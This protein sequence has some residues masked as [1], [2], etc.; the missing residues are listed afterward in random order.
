[1][2][3]PK[4]EWRVVDIFDDSQGQDVQVYEHVGNAPKSVQCGPNKWGSG[5]PQ[6]AKEVLSRAL[7]RVE[8]DEPYFI[9][10]SAEGPP[11]SSKSKRK[12]MIAWD[13]AHPNAVEPIA[14]HIYKCEV[15][16]KGYPLASYLAHANLDGSFCKKNDP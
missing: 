12:R 2:K 8:E 11:P 10:I 4:C 9:P 16:H 7:A 6:A 15:C 5:D 3:Q 14:E 13:G 1:M